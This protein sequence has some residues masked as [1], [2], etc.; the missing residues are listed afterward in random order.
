MPERWS[1]DWLEF[2]L[3]VLMKVGSEFSGVIAPNPVNEPCAR[4]KPRLLRNNS[5]GVRARPA[6]MF[7][8]ARLFLATL[9]RPSNA[10]LRGLVLLPRPTAFPDAKLPCTS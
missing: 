2:S 6:Y 5:A 1:V 3:N 8:N 10:V 7:P 4:L 9:L